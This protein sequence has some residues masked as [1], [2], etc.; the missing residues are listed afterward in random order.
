[1]A[2]EKITVEATIEKDRKKVWKL[3]TSPEHIT[4]WNQATEDWMCSKAE[5]EVREGGKFVYKMEAKDGSFGFDFSGEYTE[6]EEEEKLVYALE[7]GRTAEVKFSEEDGKT[8]ITEIFEPESENPVDQQKQ[9]WQG[10]LNSFKNY[11]EDQE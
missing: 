7:D 6:V 1:M 11:A 10:I 2:Q 3:W 9:G 5:N 8:T 4:K